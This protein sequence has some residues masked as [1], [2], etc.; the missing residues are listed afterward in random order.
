MKIVL[1]DPGGEVAGFNAG[2]GYLSAALLRA[3]HAVTVLD[4]NNNWSDR[5]PRLERVV[6]RQPL[7]VGM[8]LKTHTLA[9]AGRIVRFL[10]SKLPEVTKFLAGGPAV[11]CEGAEFLKQH[12][13]YDA[14]VSG[15]AEDRI[16]PIVGDL[17]GNGTPGVIP[18]YWK[19]EGDVLFQGV[20][21][22]I[23]K[24]DALFYPDY[25]AF[26]TS[27]LLKNKYP[28]VTS[29]GCPYD[30]V[31]CSV[32]KISGYTWRSR[33]AENVIDELIEA[34]RRHAV[35]G[36][37]IV[38]DNFTMDL[39]RAKR[40]CRLLI[41]KKVG[42]EWR[43]ING[44]RADR[45]DKELLRLMKS[46]GCTTVWFGVES[47]D[48]TVFTGIKKGESISAVTQAVV[49]A[50]DAGLRVG[51]FF[52]AGLP[53]STYAIDRQTLT[54]ARRLPFDE[55]LWSLATPYPHTPLWETA[56]ARGRMLQH[57][58][59][60]SFFKDP[61]AV[62][63]TPE[64]PAA[65]RLAM[66]YRGNIKGFSYSCFFSKKITLGQILGFLQK[67]LRYDGLRLFLHAYK[68]LAGAYHRGYVKEAF[69]RMIKKAQ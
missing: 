22:L 23:P 24:L 42:L 35:T 31:Y 21:P 33:P 65:Q 13:L 30:C 60:V 20:I 63:D 19:R 28:L 40:I 3:G 14:C 38:D 66:V 48:E 27:D 55:M 9:N 58:Q 7:I 12:P 67:L 34:K 43:C 8:S 10:K 57:Y 68:I 69:R 17:A 16:V 52:I 61:H 2:L 18:G 39:A 49:L 36:F 51:G 29:R 64:Y 56:R 47:L 25:S 32:N 6:Q 41:D 37:E 45:L 59:D 26:D 62:F 44:I 53:A 46:A 1:I 5:N 11:T 54:A 4:F 15:E 50:H